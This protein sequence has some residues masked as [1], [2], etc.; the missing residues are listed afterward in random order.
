MT[1][2]LSAA[3]Q[4]FLAER[5]PMLIDGVWHQTALTATSIKPADGAAVG[6]FAIG[7]LA[8]VE[9]AV[10]A[11]RLAFTARRWHGLPPAERAAVL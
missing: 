11:A 7:G 1:R 8:E 5:R 4:R 3:T 6:E 10:A 9:A 2:P